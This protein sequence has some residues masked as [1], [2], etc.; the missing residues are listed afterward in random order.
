M[1]SPQ[2]VARMKVTNGF[3]RMVAIG[4]APTVA[5]KAGLKIVLNGTEP[6]TISTPMAIAPI[7]ATTIQEKTK[8]I[9][10]HPTMASIG[11][12]RTAFVLT[13]G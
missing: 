4:T 9:A 2:A 11:G 7:A 3:A 10:I 5:H 1:K 12:M 6:T 13:A 8:A